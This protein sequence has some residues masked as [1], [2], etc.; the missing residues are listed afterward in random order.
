MSLASK[1]RYCPIALRPVLLPHFGL[2]SADIPVV[3]QKMC[4]VPQRNLRQATHTTHRVPASSLT[5][6]I[7]HHRT[8]T[9]SQG[10]L[11][12]PPSYSRYRF[13]PHLT[14]VCLTL[15]Y[16]NYLPQQDMFIIKKC[17]TQ[18]SR[19]TTQHLSIVCS[20]YQCVD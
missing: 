17:S 1:R 7:M 9:G 15:A 16:P 4:Q 20:P 14:I 18:E 13:P 3:L 2:H 11:L 10:M 12:V 19:F 8:R 5:K 6:N